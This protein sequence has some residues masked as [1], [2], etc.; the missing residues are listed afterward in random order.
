MTSQ[1]HRAQTMRACCEAV[2][3]LRAA[4]DHAAG[5]IRLQMKIL[6]AINAVAAIL[7]EVRAPAGGDLHA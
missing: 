5:D 1:D 6:S 4:L 7:D 3:D 2:D